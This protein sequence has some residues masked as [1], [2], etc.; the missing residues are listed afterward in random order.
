MTRVAF[1][2]LAK[3]FDMY[4]DRRRCDIRHDLAPDTFDQLSAFNHLAGSLKQKL[5]DEELF[6]RDAR[7]RLAIAKHDLGPDVELNTLGAK[8][9]TTSSK[10]ATAWG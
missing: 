7:Q 10:S 2:P 8:D 3:S 1:E 4:V 5:Q 6:L 9:T